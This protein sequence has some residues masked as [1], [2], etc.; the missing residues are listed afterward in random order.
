MPFLQPH[1]SLNI[2]F[3]SWEGLM[4]LDGDRWIMLNLVDYKKFVLDIWMGDWIQ[5]MKW[6]KSILETLHLTMMSIWTELYLEY[7]NLLFLFI[8]FLKNTTA[9][10]KLYGS[11]SRVCKKWPDQTMDSLI[12]TEFYRNFCFRG[13]HVEPRS[14]NACRRSKRSWGRWGRRSRQTTKCPSLSLKIWRNQ[15]VSK[16]NWQCLLFGSSSAL[17]WSLKFPKF[18]GF[19]WRPTCR[20]PG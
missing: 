10:I 15:A 4:T 20:V 2:H 18:L 8:L 1:A 9:D 17:V 14:F 3:C 11:R 16:Q 6:W 12:I 19:H 13:G 7:I 5:K